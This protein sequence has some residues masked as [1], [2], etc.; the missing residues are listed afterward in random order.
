MVDVTMPPVD[1]LAVDILHHL[2]PALDGV[3][4]VDC[5]HNAR[6]VDVV[7][8]VRVHTCAV[9]VGSMDCDDVAWRRR[10]CAVVSPRP[11]GWKVVVV[12][13]PRAYAYRCRTDVVVPASDTPC[14]AVVLISS[15]HPRR[16]HRRPLL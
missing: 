5:N 15:H 9:V 1:N 13:S 12:A 2:V 7:V 11:G 6:T 3:D 8:V 10:T 14:D 16:R 4:D